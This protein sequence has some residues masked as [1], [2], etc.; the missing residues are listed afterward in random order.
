[1]ITYSAAAAVPVRSLGLNRRALLGLLVIAAM[2]M[3]RHALAEVPQADAVATIKQFNQALLA[4]M[5]AGDHTGFGQRFQMIA[6]AVDR[7]FDLPAVL[8][9]SVGPS[10]TNLSQG[11]QDRLLDAFRR[12]TVASYVSNF[13]SYSGQQL[14]VTPETRSLGVD[15]LI[16]ESQIR[17]VNGDVI[18]LDYVMKQS[19][20]GWKVVDVLANGSISRVAVQRSDFRHLLSKG[21]GDALVASLQ[22]KTSDLSGGTLA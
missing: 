10:W 19:A 22:R 18:A 3:G 4:S 7:A 8:E 9:I 14:T 5:K 12:Y 15:R 21:G 17:P 20:A 11:Q 2:P 16:V 13:D 1:M 6:P